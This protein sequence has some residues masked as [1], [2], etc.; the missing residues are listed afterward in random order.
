MAY[1]TTPKTQ[2]H[3]LQYS[4][5]TN[6]L[7]ELAEVKTRTKY[8]RAGKAE[9]LANIETGEITHASLLHEV[10]YLDDAQFVKIFAAGVIAMFDLSR[11]AQK[12]FHF[13]LKQYEA[14]KMTGK[15]AASVELFWFDNKLAG[16]HI[17]I[18]EQTFNRGL[19]ELID[20]QF[21]YP[22]IPNSYWV[23]Q[24]LF[25]KGDR[26]I[27]MKEY[28]RNKALPDKTQK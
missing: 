7:A 9:A 3:R 6:P 25:F 15:W 5:E 14:T 13:V 8:V 19:R 21:L 18:T 27:F 23:N 24:N 20:K 12:V 1:A 26:A 10:Q 17:G 2:L 28:R 22:R 11:T 4:P 16:Q